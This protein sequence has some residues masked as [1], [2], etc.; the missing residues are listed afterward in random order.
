MAVMAVA[1]KREELLFKHDDRQLAGEKVI[2]DRSRS[3]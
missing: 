1:E 2:K 3:G